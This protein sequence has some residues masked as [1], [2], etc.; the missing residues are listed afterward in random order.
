MS[1]SP[2]SLPQD[3]RISLDT[4][5]GLFRCCPS[6]APPA[7]H[8]HSSTWDLAYTLW[9][10]SP[11]CPPDP[12]TA[13]PQPQEDGR[14]I[15]FLASYSV[16]LGTACHVN[17]PGMAASNLVSHCDQGLLGLG[18]KCVTLTEAQPWY[19]R[20]CF[21]LSSPLP[22]K[23]SERQGRAERRTF[24]VSILVRALTSPQPPRATLWKPQSRRKVCH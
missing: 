2:P 21:S 23:E 6:L 15:Q 14:E 1:Q 12:S 18:N 16:E 20:S 4:P 3:I 24:D 8:S 11:S 22:Q 7:C 13:S 19:P 17:L 5:M 10:T 9:R